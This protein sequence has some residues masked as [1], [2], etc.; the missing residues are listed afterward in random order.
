MGRKVRGRARLRVIEILKRQAD[1]GLVVKCLQ[2]QHHQAGQQTG[3]AQGDDTQC[4]DL[5]RRRQS[6]R[7]DFRAQPLA[8]NEDL[9][10]EAENQAQQDREG[11]R[12]YRPF[13]CAHQ[14]STR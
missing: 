12:F 7:V 5:R 9:S 13:A 2:P 1:T 4:A 6:G 10:R 8:R 14:S 11:N 3:F